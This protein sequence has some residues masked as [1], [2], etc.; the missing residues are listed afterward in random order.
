MERVRTF[1]ASAALAATALAFA[2][3]AAP[4]AVQSNRQEVASVEFVGNR[5][6]SDRELRR[7]I[8][9][10]RSSCPLVLAF[11]TCALGIDWGRDRFYHSTRI[12]ADDAERLAYLYRAHG[13]RRA[14]VDTETA[15]HDDGAVV[16][17]FLVDEGEPY[18]VGSINFAGDALPSDL[19][20]DAGLPIGVGDPLSFLYLGQ[21][22]DTLA[23]RLRDSGYAFA[24]VFRR[25]RLPAGSDTATVTY[26]VELGPLAT[27]GPLR[28]AGNRLLDDDVV[29][30]RLPFR[31]GDRYREHQIGDAQ[32]SLH[33]IEIVARASVRVDAASIEGTAGSATAD[34]VVPI[35]VEVEEG[36]LHR[37]R[38]G[39]GL[40]S[41]ECINVQGLWSSRNFFGGGRLLQ[42]RA[43]VSNLLAGALQSSPLCSQAG[44][45]DYGRVNWAAG[46]DFSQPAFLSPSARIFGGVFAERQSQK[47]IFVRDAFGVDL[48]LSRSMGAG[49]V[50]GF[51]FRPELSRLDAAE[52]TLCATFLACAY[53]DI[54]ALAESTWLTPAALSLLVDRTVGVLSPRGGFRALLD[55]EYAGGITGSDFSYVRVFADGSVYGEIDSGAVLAFRLRAGRIRPGS[56]TPF[57]AAQGGRSRF[58]PSYLVPAQ[59]R[60]Y[61]GGASSVRGFAQS[62]LGPRILSV[63]VEQLLRRR[64]AGGEPTCSPAAVRNATCD[65]SPLAGS[66]LY[67]LRPIGGMGTLEASAEL[68]FDISGSPL[69]GAAFVDVGQVW[70]RGLRLDD[71][72]VTPGVGIRYDTAFGPVRMDVAY[73]FREPERLQ[74]VTSQIRPFV[75]GRDEASDRIDIG[76]PGGAGEHIEWVVSE[77]LALLEPLV[78]FGDAPGFSLRRFQLHFSI[79]QAF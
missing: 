43:R 67:Q 56:E 36:D 54:A 16:V 11:T 37:V 3:R 55:L 79:G 77:D 40:N 66:D 64:E 9:T 41:A 76:P 15:P 45:G 49:T 7:A 63:G 61:G 10:R 31:E 5:A 20:I 22:S 48:G 68:R 73:S 32:R 34:S 6:F 75:A 47:N 25:F 19:E 78:L 27:I 23:R 42:A 71:L 1:A 72:E 60:F 58:G 18:R 46:L 57:S 62:T 26:N 14:T 50:A 35:V 52:V 70:P 21:A 28:V 33:E 2:P 59:K 53:N 44:T 4:G 39:G 13:F 38:A 51:R 65:G 24:E 69:G 74:V 17:R 29:L 8:R 12:L 30:N